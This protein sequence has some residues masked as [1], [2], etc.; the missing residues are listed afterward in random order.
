MS[1][2]SASRFTNVARNINEIGRDLIAVN[3]CVGHGNFLPWIDADFG[4]SE[5]HARRIM[6]VAETSGIK[7]NM[8]LDLKPSILYALAAPA[9]PSALPPADQPGEQFNERGGEANK[10]VRVDAHN[11]GSIGGRDDPAREPQND[12]PRFPMGRLKVT[13]S[14]APRQRLPFG[15]SGCAARRAAISDGVTR[16]PASILRSNSL[17]KSSGSV[18][19]DSKAIT[20]QDKP[21]KIAGRSA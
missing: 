6:N 11:V 13:I 4:M 7:S 8:M 5:Q 10:F 17:L 2:D 15:A 21:C 14:N 1:E 16:S 19:D 18:G 3:D 20:C 12:G 9:P